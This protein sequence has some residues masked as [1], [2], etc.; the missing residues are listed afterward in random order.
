MIAIAFWGPRKDPV[1]NIWVIEFG[2]IACMSVIPLALIFGP[3]RGI[4]LF[5]RAID[6]SFGVFGLLPLGLA[7]R[8]AWRLARLEQGPI[9]KPI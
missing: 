5:W 8:A 4:P 9:V 3:L 6:C 1:R 2:M 7:H